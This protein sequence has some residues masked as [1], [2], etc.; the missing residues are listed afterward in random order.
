LVEIVTRQML[1][2][3]LYRW[4]IPFTPVSQRVEKKLTL[5]CYSN[6]INMYLPRFRLPVS[7]TPGNPPSNGPKSH[8]EY[9]ILSISSHSLN[10]PPIISCRNCLCG[11]IRNRTRRLRNRNITGH[12]ICS[13]RC[14]D[15]SCS[16]CGCEIFDI[17]N[18]VC[19]YVGV[20]LSNEDIIGGGYI[21]SVRVCLGVVD[22]LC[23]G[24]VVGIGVSL[25]FRVG[26]CHEKSVRDTGGL[27]FGLNCS[28]SGSRYGND[29]CR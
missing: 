8:D 6:L 4:L 22:I 27:G 20:G 23:S 25:G 12:R 10:P 2:V 7:R 26:L 13:C 3:E 18:G 1:K 11:L 15:I 21:F 5:C 29:G 19:F 9:H 24:F 17:G 16:G 28:G 14:R